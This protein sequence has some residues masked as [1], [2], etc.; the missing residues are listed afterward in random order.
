MVLGFALRFFY[1]K[2]LVQM[3]TRQL[4]CLIRLGL[5]APNRCQT[6]LCSEYH[7]VEAL[8]LSYARGLQSVTPLKCVALI[9]KSFTQVCLSF[10]H[11]SNRL[12]LQ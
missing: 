12:I 8:L 11:Y 3:L 1:V 4:R 7:A 9:Q 2:E 5:S 10:A 6:K